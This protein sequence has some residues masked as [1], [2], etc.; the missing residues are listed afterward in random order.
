MSTRSK[1]QAKQ[2]VLRDLKVSSTYCEQLNEF[3]LISPDRLSDDSFAQQKTKDAF[4]F[5]VG[6]HQLALS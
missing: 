5:F 3:A 1:S 4:R 6:S 2:L